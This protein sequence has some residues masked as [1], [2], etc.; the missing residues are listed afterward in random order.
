MADQDGP[1]GGMLLSDDHG[2]WD[3]V[4]PADLEKNPLPPVA[5]DGTAECF[6]CKQRFPLAQLEIT[7]AGGTI[8]AYACKPCLLRAAQANTPA[9]DVENMSLRSRSLGRTIAVIGAIAVAI[10]IGVAIY[11][12]RVP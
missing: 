6:Q 4:R 11:L 12:A 10:G 3:P 8:N 9:M 2:T 1:F 5:A 7:P